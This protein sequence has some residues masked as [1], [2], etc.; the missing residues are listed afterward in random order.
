[1]SANKR[2]RTI[3]NDDQI[4]MMEK[5]LQDD[6]HMRLKSNTLQIWVDKLNQCVSIKL[7]LFFTQVSVYILIIT[8]TNMLYKIYCRDPKLQLHN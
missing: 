4:S 1:M 7:N 6:P 8:L 3:M 2:K 5:E